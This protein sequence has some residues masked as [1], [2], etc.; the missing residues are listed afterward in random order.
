MTDHAEYPAPVS[1]LER[2]R[3]ISAEQDA[4]ASEAG[5]L[6]RCHE[7]W[8]SN[9]LPRAWGDFLQAVERETGAYFQSV[10]EYEDRKY[11]ARPHAD[12]MRYSDRHE[13]DAYVIPWGFVYPE[14]RE[15]FKA[16]VLADVKAE[17]AERDTSRR[18]RTSTGGTQL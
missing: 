16:Q 2:M 12:G 14:T 10:Y 5:E 17:K 1:D 13:F 11:A 18:L 15:S 9:W 3:A 6:F 4:L 8:L 7:S